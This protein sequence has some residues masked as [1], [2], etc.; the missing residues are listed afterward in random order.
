MEH[1]RG[2]LGFDAVGPRN[3]PLASGPLHLPSLWPFT[4]FHLLLAFFLLFNKLAGLKGVGSLAAAF[5][6]VIW[7]KV[8]LCF[9]YCFSVIKR[10]Y[11]K[12][13]VRVVWT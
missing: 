2:I 3:T 8:S 11:F 1:T 10:F 5:Q 4:C 9:V 12:H 6:H 7:Q 13:L